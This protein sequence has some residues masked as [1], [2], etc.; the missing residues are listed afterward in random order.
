MIPSAA[1]LAVLP[2]LLAGPSCGHDFDFHVLSWLEAATQLAHLHWPHWAYTPAFN[3]GEPRFIFYPPLSWALGALLGLAL[4]WHLVPAAFTFLALTLSGFTAHRL[5]RRY[6]S[7]DSAALAAVLYLTNPYMLFT[8]YERTAYGELLAAAWMPLLL[9]AALAPELRIVGLAAPVA[10]LWLSNAPAGVMGCYALALLIAVRLVLPGARTGRRLSARRAVAG[11]M[12][13]L[14]LPAFYL[15]PAA[16]EQR[17]IQADMA[18]IEGMRIAD[19]TLFHRMPAS[20]DHA[21]HDAVLSSASSIALGLLIAI[22]IGLAL[23]W[24]RRGEGFYL[25]LASLTVVIAFLLTAP[26]LPIWAHAPE[27]RFL[28]FPWRLAAL[29][30]GVLAVLAACALDRLRL[31]PLRFTLGAAVLGC[32][33]ILT[34]WHSF[35]QPCDDEDTVEARAALYHSPDGTE[36]TD[37]YT[38]A[39]ADNEALKQGDPGFW[40]VPAGEPVDTPAPAVHEAAQAPHHLLFNLPQQEYLI[41][42][43]RRYPGWT[44]KVNG[45]AVANSMEGRDDGLISVLLPA[46]HD[47]VDLEYHPPLD[48]Q[49]GLALSL[50]AMLAAAAI[51]RFE[52]RGGGTATLPDDLL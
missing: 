19:N 46:G 8:A 40:L 17:F 22:A 26:S 43:R 7:A 47:V 51:R 29:L 42:N 10:L 32:V 37:E 3:A 12:L 5:T 13:G 18:V 44:A 48:Q 31:T 35:H 39:V 23:S 2:L 14:L 34:A 1:L 21:L 38:P 28:Q 41:L 52:G 45:Q 25:P 4:P 24:R 49:V 50:F 6:A 11:V 33:L 36:A 30:A 16:Y 27:L 15:V 20:A 9:L